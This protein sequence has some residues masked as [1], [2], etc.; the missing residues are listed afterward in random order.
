MFVL[1]MLNVHKNDIMT[2]TSFVELT[3]AIVENV[4][5]AV[6]ILLTDECDFEWRVQRS[7]I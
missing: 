7:V 1:G 3:K 6:V 4:G 5:F 2:L